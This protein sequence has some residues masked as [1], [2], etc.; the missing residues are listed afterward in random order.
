MMAITPPLRRPEC[1]RAAWTRRAHTG[2][3]TV[4]PGTADLERCLASR[5]SCAPAPRKGGG[6]G[7]F[8]VGCRRTPYG[9]YFDPRSWR[10]TSP[11]S[12]VVACV[13]PGA[14]GERIRKARR[15][16]PRVSWRQSALEPGVMPL[17]DGRGARAGW[18]RRGWG[19]A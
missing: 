12:E 8:I 19:G 5:I 7:I 10:P 11:W 18:A 1:T 2:V 3:R 14:L 16:E 15:N 4:G 13:A 9:G 17:E 6:A